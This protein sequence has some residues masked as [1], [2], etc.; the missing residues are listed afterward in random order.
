M[1]QICTPKVPRMLNPTY[2]LTYILFVDLIIIIP[3]GAKK[4][5]RV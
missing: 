2:H 3:G 1:Y 4:S 5:I